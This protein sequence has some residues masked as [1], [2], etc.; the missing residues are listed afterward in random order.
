[1]H[2]ARPRLPSDTEL[3]L[4]TPANQ[5]KPDLGVERSG[6]AELSVHGRFHHQSL[7]VALYRRDTSDY[8]DFG[9]RPGETAFHAR[10]FGMFRDHGLD[11]SWRWHPELRWLD[12]LGLGYHYAHVHLDQSAGKNGLHIPTSTWRVHLRLPI[13]ARLH[14]SIDARRPQF[15]SQ[16]TVWLVGM[17]LQWQAKHV[18]IGLRVSNLFDKRIIETG[19]APIP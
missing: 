7:N 2:D 11:V 12:G 1:R 19:F 9:R 17:R 15:T 16:P 5:G 3:Y 6:Y 8:I 18:R 4:D 13:V 10:N 14:L